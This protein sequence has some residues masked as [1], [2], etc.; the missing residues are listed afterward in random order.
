MDTCS[1]KKWVDEVGE[2]WRVEGSRYRVG[3]ENDY[4][5][6]GNVPPLVKPLGLEYSLNRWSCS[7]I[8]ASFQ[9]S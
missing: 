9:E 4:G 3:L 2:E 1:G 6:K 5:C 7:Y 8:A